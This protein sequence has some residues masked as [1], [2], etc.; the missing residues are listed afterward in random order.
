MTDLTS[1]QMAGLPAEEIKLH[2][3]F[4]ALAVEGT[5]LNAVEATVVLTIAAQ[6]TAGD[7]MTIAGKRYTFVANGQDDLEGEV[8]IGT[9]LATAKT[10]I[11]AAIKGTDG[12]NTENEYITCGTF[13]TND[14]TITAKVAGALA[15]SYGTT[16]TFTN[17]GNIFSHPHLT[18][19]VDGSI[20]VP[21][22]I[23]IDGTNLY[24]CTAVN[25]VSG[26]NWRKIAHSAL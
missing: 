26:K 22:K 13:S 16:E 23:M 6:P 10:A 24:V 14:L 1:E 7:T 3:L 9:D 11:I 17:V 18:S 12:H 8:T 25:L 19:G 20:G 15:N 21:G 4:K 5:A 2:E